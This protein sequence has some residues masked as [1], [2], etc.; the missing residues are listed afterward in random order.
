MNVY[1]AEKKVKYVLKDTKQIVQPAK[2][3]DKERTLESILGVTSGPGV[4]AWAIR[5][6]ASTY[7]VYLLT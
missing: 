7:I 3:N 4:D 5:C 6:T 2:G 1:D